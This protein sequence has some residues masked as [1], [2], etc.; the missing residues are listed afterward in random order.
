MDKLLFL[1]VSMQEISFELIIMGW[2]LLL[3]I[4]AGRSLA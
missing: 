1:S 2:N 3:P 4:S